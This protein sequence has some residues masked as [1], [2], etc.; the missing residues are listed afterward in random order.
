MFQLSVTYVVLSWYFMMF[1]IITCS[2]KILRFK[3]V[4]SVTYKARIGADNAV[5][6]AG[7][8]HD[9]HH[10]QSNATWPGIAFGHLSA[11]LIQG[12]QIVVFHS[13]K[14]IHG[15]LKLQ[16]KLFLYKLEKKTAF[17]SR[18]QL[19]DHT[20]CFPYSN[21]IVSV[22]HFPQVF[23]RSSSRHPLVCIHFCTV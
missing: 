21:H 22:D 12:T 3:R 8:V 20:S 2:N 14:G 7:T 16:F 11:L 13:E 10:L 1:C 17:R 18:F 6:A 5:T 19:M 23:R 9:S 4:R 15:E